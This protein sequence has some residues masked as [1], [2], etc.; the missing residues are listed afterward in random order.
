MAT[1]ACR[2]GAIKVNSESAKPSREVFPGDRIQLRKDQIHYTLEVLEIP[3]SRVAAKL[4]NLFRVDTTPVE[5]LES[6]ELMK[7]SKEYY[8][9][10]GEGR[11]TKKDRR[12]LDDFTE[13]TE[14]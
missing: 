9:Q 14:D 12:D 13:A 6:R 3:E 4:V 10:K 11:P 7:L 5:S 8:R 1:Q 2:K